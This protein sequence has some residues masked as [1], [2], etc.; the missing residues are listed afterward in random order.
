[1][2]I[3]SNYDANFTAGGI[4][5]NEFI[6]LEDMLLSENFVERIC[7]EEEENNVMGVATNSARKRIISEIKRRYNVVPNDFW[8]LFFGWNEN[9]QKLA[10]FFLCLKTYPLIFDIH[11]EV[12]LKKFKVGSSLNAYDIQMQI[13]EIASSDDGVASWSVSTLKK[14]NVQYRKALK[15]VGLWNGERFLEATNTSSQFWSYFEDH[16]EAWFLSAC[17]KN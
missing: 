15:D 11:F 9:E 6:S 16:H 13:D 12:T 17:F 4:L 10:L 14:M 3:K 2:K 1:M 8:I 7:I 5:F